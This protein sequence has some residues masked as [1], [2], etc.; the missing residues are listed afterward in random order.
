MLYL[1]EPDV[2]KLLPMPRAISLMRQV[3]TDLAQNKA[4]N[5]PRHRVILPTGSVLH[6]MAAGNESYFGAKV[7]ATNLR[8]GAHFLFLLY[9]SADAAPLAIIEA[10]HLGQIRTGAASGYATDLLARENA[11]TLAIIGSGFQ[12][13]AQVDAIAAVRPLREIRVWSRKPE[14]RE[15]FAETLRAKGHANVSI[16]ASAEA[17]VRGAAIVVTSTNSKNPVFE[18][19]WIAEG[20]HI[21]ATGSN[22]ANRRELPAEILSRATLIAVDSKEQAKM[23]SGDLLLASEEEWDGHNL[24]ELQEVSGRTDSRAITIFKSNGLALQDV[25]AAGWVY[26]EAVRLGIGAPIPA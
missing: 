24:V 18:A 21:N 7:Y 9:R 23:E 17:A 1:T 15:R 6:Y 8:T 16:A 20:T 2:L 14:R 10:N 11:D 12:A 26:E 4:V 19:E 5:Q 25:A 13:E 3:F 22:Q